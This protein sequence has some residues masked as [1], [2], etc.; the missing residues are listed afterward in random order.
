MN[1]L[2]PW[3]DLTPTRRPPDEG[4]VMGTVVS[5]YDQATGLVE[6]HV[7]GAPAGQT[8]ITPSSAG[9]TY[10]RAGVRVSRDTSGAATMAHVPTGRAPTGTKTV[11]V[12]ETGRALQDLTGRINALADTNDTDIP[13]LGWDSGIR[14][15][16][17]DVPP[18]YWN[19]LP[20]F[21]GGALA[22][23]A[24]FDVDGE[25]EAYEVPVLVP[26]L[27]AVS[28]RVHAWSTSWDASVTA[29]ISI[30]RAGADTPT[31]VLDTE[32]R[33][34]AYAP[35]SHYA[36]PTAYGIVRLAKGDTISL[37]VHNAQ[38]ST[39]G[40]WGWAISAHLV[41]KTTERKKP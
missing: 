30:H 8:V 22:A 17:I 20:L 37:L 16:A 2:S 18:T 32:P 14:T 4:I 25:T 31:N 11:A 7:D 21:N 13:V 38:A 36:C 10:I 1:G 19:R 35:Q 41:S 6:V 29:G 34:E 24:G 15:A 9:L 26:G 28:G 40:M 23:C 5:I 12:G 3:L 27:Y 39:V 33:G